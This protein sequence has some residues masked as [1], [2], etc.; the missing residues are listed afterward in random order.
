MLVLPE[1]GEQPPAQ[2]LQVGRG[3]GAAGDEGAGP[4][5]GGDP[6]SQHDLLGPRRQPLGQ[7]RHLRLLQQPLGQVED[8]LDPGLLGPGPD[9]VRF[10]LAAHQQVERVGQDGL[11]RPRL[12]RDRVQPLAE[13]QFRPL[14]Q[15]QV[16]DPELAQHGLCVATGA[17]RLSPVF[18]SLRAQPARLF[19]GRAGL[20]EVL[21]ADQGEAEGGADEGEDR[22]DQDDLVEAA[23]EGDVGG[24]DGFVRGSPAA[25]AARRR[26]GSR[27]R[28]PLR[29][30]RAG[31]CGS[32]SA[33]FESTRDWKTAPSPAT[34]V[35][36]PTW[37]KVV[38]IPDPI[39][40]FSTG[41][42]AIAA[43]PMPGLVM[44]MPM[45]ATRKPAS[46]VVQPESARDAVHQQQAEPDQRQAR[47]RAGPGSGSCA[48]APRR[49]ARR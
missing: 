34:P 42:T 19:A 13:P 3:R 11:P 12:P 22:G 44:P 20:H 5:A 7:L 23:D 28:R 37:R 35:A 2:Q 41:T 27:P 26:R 36:I 17:D 6:P 33:S 1:E 25:A 24:V 14:D 9:D 31:A 18:R 32:S 15:Q 45:P 46:S 10:R 29:R 39:P 16:L 47:C 4:P 49:S 21:G 40:D 48:R 30:G 38:L 8:A 43:W